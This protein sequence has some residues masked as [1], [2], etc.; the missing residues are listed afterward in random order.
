MAA[1]VV[2]RY[3]RKYIAQKKF[4]MRKSATISLQCAIR[5]KIATKELLELKKE[6]KDVGKLKNAN[7][8]LKEEM[9]TLRAMLSAQAKESAAGAA[10]MKELKE[11]EARIAE[12]EKRIAEIEKELEDAKATVHKLTTDMQRQTEENAKDKSELAHL[13]ARRPSKMPD[14]PPIHRRKPSSLNAESFE[15]VVNPAVLQEHMSKVAR[16]EEELEEERF[17]RREADGEIIKLRAAINGVSLNSDEV[18]ALLAPQISAS[19]AVSV[20]STDNNDFDDDGKRYVA[21]WCMIYSRCFLPLGFIF[22]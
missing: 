1:I 11:K 13:R 3:Y 6:Q 15:G 5:V 9:A 8:K 12:L 22:N 14:S 4:R 21:A 18:K 10:H 7:V 17:L 19:S 20:A 2:Q 16:L